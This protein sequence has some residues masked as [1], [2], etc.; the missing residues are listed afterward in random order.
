MTELITYIFEFI[1]MG[2]SF[3][4]AFLLLM[5]MKRS[6]VPVGNASLAIASIF[7]GI[8]ALSTI[9]YSL[10]GEASVIIILFKMGLI[11]LLMAVFFL[12]YTMQ[13]LVYSSKWIKIKKMKKFLWIPLITLIL[14]VL[15]LIFTDY[16][17]VINAA[18]AETHFEPFQFMLY[19][20]YIAFMILYSTISLY[21][22]GLKKVTGES[23]KNMQFFFMG[24]LFFLGALVID[25]LNNI[26]EYE[27]LFDTLLFASLAIGV[28]LMARAFYGKK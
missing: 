11:S 2:I 13:V 18:T 1:T 17:T 15:I 8:F 19:A 10:I 9:L 25:V 27:V 20:L 6:L 3:L 26:F 16:I 22:F 14:I 7:L 12:Y 23:K 4:V 21:K 5:R 28:I 24:L